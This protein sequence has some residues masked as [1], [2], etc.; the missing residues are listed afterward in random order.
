MNFP[1]GWRTARAPPLFTDFATSCAGLGLRVERP[2]QL[3][4]ALR[5][6]PAHGGAALLEIIAD[7][8]FI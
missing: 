8:E 5:K 2:E 6:V 3:N 4:A 1:S 7:P